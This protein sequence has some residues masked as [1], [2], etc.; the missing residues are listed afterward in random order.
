MT[1]IAIAGGLGDVAPRPGATARE[2]PTGLPLPVEIDYSVVSAVSETLKQLQ[3]DTVISTLNLHWPGASESQINLIRGAA[4]SGVVSGFLPSE[5]NIDYNASEEY[6]IVPSQSGSPITI[7][8]PTVDMPYPPRGEFL[9][10]REELDR[11]PNLTYSLIRNGYFMDYLGM[12][13]VESYLHPLYNIL[14]LAAYKAVI[15]GDGDVPVVWTHTKDVAKFVTALVGIPAD[16]WHQKTFVWCGH[17][18][19][20]PQ[21]L[22]HPWNTFCLFDE[23]YLSRLGCGLGAITQIIR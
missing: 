7:C 18:R 21:S 22:D 9:R 23:T 8:M 11:H 15:P 16:Q 2:V 4:A 14:D 10:A 19:N 20:F 5:F 17:C 13:Y 1:V 3:A 6:G 12:P